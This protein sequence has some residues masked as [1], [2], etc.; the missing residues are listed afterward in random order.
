MTAITANTETAILKRLIEP[1]EA[2][3]V[4]EAARYI[5]ALDFNQA[6]VDR[7][8]ELAAKAREG[9]LS[10]EERLEVENYEHVGHL[11]AFL[12]AKARISLK[13]RGLSS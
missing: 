10:S 4:P 11:L 6:D 2:D 7:M 9:S 3:L 1:E 8:N 5:L 12:Q 13:G